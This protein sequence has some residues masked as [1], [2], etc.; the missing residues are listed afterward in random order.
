MSPEYCN[1][2]QY[3]EGRHEYYSLG[4]NDSLFNQRLAEYFAL[5]SP[6]EAVLRDHAL[7]SSATAAHNPSKCHACRYISTPIN[8][9]RS[10]LRK[11]NAPLVVEVAQHDQQP[12][13]YFAEGVLDWDLDVVKG[14]VGGARGA[15]VRRLHLLR[16]DTLAALNEH[17][18]EP[19]IRT[20]SSGEVVAEMTI[21]DPPNN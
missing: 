10:T 18:R 11:E 12:G 21:R 8:P 6:F 14:D 7:R 9:H 17:D 5:R 15:R 19:A 3:G 4:A 1:I 16:G 13:V 2:H 20:A